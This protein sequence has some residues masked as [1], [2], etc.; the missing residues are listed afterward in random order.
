V[1]P[2]AID[3]GMVEV[4]EPITTVRIYNTNTKKYIIARVPVENGK[5]K[6]TGDYS[7]SGIPGT[8]ARI[9]LEFQ[10]PGGS[11]TGKL[12]PTGNVTD[13]LDTPYGHF[14]VSIVDA[15][16][17]LVF[18][19][20]SDLGLTGVELPPAVDGNPELLKKIESIRAAA[21]VKT[22]LAASPAEATTKSPAV[23]KIAFVAPPVDYATLSGATVQA[24][25]I[26]VVARIMSM[27]RL[28]AAYAI[29]GAICTAGAAKIEGSLV[30]EMIPVERQEDKL[31][32]LGH[33]G[34][35]LDV[36]V[37]MEKQDGTFVYQ[38]GTAFRT[39]RRLMEGYVYVPEQFFHN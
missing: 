17:P 29:T 33:P 19:R 14:A 39:A 30:W 9:G 27:G 7:I 37:E 21:A 18:L 26:D 13:V 12:L 15:A 28:H 25:D 36:E 8:G 11:V 5:A 23:P 16:N 1:G 3:E 35:T 38:K 20:A 6:V 32:R 34:G 10:Q 4:E 2:Y 31:V 24:A 22:G